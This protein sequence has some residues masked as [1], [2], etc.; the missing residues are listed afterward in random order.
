MDLYGQKELSK[1]KSKYII[2]SNPVTKYL[3]SFKRAFKPH[4]LNV[5]LDLKGNDLF[6]CETGDII[7]MKT[8]YEKQLSDFKYFY[9]RYLATKKFL[10]FNLISKY[11]SKFLIRLLNTYLK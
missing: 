4:D 7:S 9:T 5:I 6:F 1:I 11:N 3:F 10:I 2:T 8:N